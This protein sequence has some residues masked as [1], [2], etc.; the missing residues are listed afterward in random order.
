M[1]STLTMKNHVSHLCKTL[2][3]QLRNISR[4]RRYLDK[5]SCNHI[6]HALVI[7]RLD[8]GNSLLIGTTDSNLQR[9]QR[10]QNQAIR[11]ICG[12]THRDHVSPHHVKLHWLPIRERI[13]FKLFTIIF[14]CLHGSAP[15]YLQDEIHLYSSL[16]RGHHRLRSALD[17]T[18]LYVPFTRRCIVDYSF[19]IF[20]PR[21]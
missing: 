21:I 8:Y 5:D 10:I 19:Y 12:L 18:R 1:D 6:V 3:F 11:L 7:S 14:Q 15:R 17:S 9:L 20:G 16:D 4:I 2:N 13:N